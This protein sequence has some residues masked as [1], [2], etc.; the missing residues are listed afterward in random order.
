MVTLKGN[1]II[2]MYTRTINDFATIKNEHY[3]FTFPFR[4][5]EMKM[6]Y[7]QYIKEKHMM[8]QPFGI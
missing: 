3:I 4:E 7:P 2:Y 8:Y 5:V 1:N 6:L